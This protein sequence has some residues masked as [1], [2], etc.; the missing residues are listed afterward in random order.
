MQ[1]FR[2]AAL[3]AIPRKREVEPGL[4]INSYQSYLKTKMLPF[5]FHF[6][7][8]YFLL[9]FV[10]TCLLLKGF[11]LLFFKLL[12]GWYKRPRTQTWYIALWP[13][14]VSELL[15]ILMCLENTLAE[16]LRRNKECQNCTICRKYP[17]A[18]VIAWKHKFSKQKLL[19]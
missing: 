18:L 13:L 11:C 8:S 17:Y 12:R 10:P 14:H 3:T 5:Y 7:G 6:F 9:C 16:M 15:N 1:P 2:Q 19:G 4:A